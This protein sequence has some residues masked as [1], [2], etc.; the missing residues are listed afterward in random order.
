MGEIIICQFPLVLRKIADL[1]TQHL[2]GIKQTYLHP[3]SI[4]HV[5]YSIF[6]DED[7]HQVEDI[8]HAVVY[9]EPDVVVLLRLILRED[10]SEGDDPGVV[11]KAHRHHR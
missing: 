4:L 1:F 11:E 7:I 3:E 2:L 10:V 6:E 5:H 8:H 9:D